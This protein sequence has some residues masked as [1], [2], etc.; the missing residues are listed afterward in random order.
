MP[1]LSTFTPLGSHLNAPGIALP[2]RQSGFRRQCRAERPT[3]LCFAKKEENK[4]E[5][6]IL[7]ATLLTTW[8]VWAGLSAW[9]KRSGKRWH[10]KPV[11]AICASFAGMIVLVVGATLGG[12]GNNRVEPVATASGPVAVTPVP[13]MAAAETDA[14]VAEAAPPEPIVVASSQSMPPAAA[15]APDLKPSLEMTHTHYAKK[16]NR[17]LKELGFAY[18]ISPLM[19]P[20]V[21]QDGFYE[22]HGYLGKY[23]G[24]IAI[25][26]E[27][28]GKI[29]ELSGVGVGDGSP[30]SEYE[31]LMLGAAV[32]AAAVPEMSHEMMLETVPELL[33]S[34]EKGVTRTRQL[35]VYESE[36]FGVW[37]N[38]K[39]LAQTN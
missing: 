1:W 30:R 15:K 34:G 14:P 21:V 29:I 17:L 32:M 8:A 35:S 16:L 13:P 36:N 26:S 7:L 19:N 12:Y 4:M 5:I 25:V 24:Y 2:V 31:I 38:V 3:R 20:G 18:R 11:P 28:T 27:E 33:A 39:P 6:M 22:F 9:I 10:W 23:A 37:F